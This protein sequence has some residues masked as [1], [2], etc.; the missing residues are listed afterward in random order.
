MKRRT[1]VKDTF[2]TFDYGRMDRRAARL[3]VCW[4]LLLAAILAA[5]GFF[6]GEGGYLTAWAVSLLGAVVL[7]YVMSIPRRVVVGD[8]ALEIRCIVEITHIKYADLR[9]I[10]RI[11]PEAMKKKFVFFGSY[12]F[13][14]YY[15][16][17]ID[18]KS[19]ETLKL[20]CKQWDNFI[21]ITDAY[22]KR[23]IISSPAPDD[24]VA[25]VTRAIRNNSDSAHGERTRG[26]KATRNTKTTTTTT[27]QP[28]ANDTAEIPLRCP[29]SPLEQNILN[30][31]RPPFAARPCH[32]RQD[33]RIHARLHIGSHIRHNTAFRTSYQT[34]RL[35]VRYRAFLPVSVQRH[36]HRRLPVR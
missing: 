2:R 35:F 32:E 29:P 16:Y 26:E 5:E 13:F 1:T 36:P 11:P 10:R 31:R 27:K 22:E 9:S 28:P 19:W 3:T 24:L 14:G 7:L 30:L 18:G 20:Y 21:E 12:G 25:A 17:Y 8:T 33:Q 23:Y 15:G 34:C 6:W 4:L